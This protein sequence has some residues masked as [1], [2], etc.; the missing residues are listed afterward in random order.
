M[1]ADPGYLYA[2]RVD[3]LDAMAESVLDAQVPDVRE[4]G[5]DPDI[6]WSA[7]SARGRPPLPA[8]V[9]VLEQLQQDVAARARAHLACAGRDQG[10]GSP[11]AR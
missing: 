3:R 11:S 7:R 2:A 6:G 8:A 4:P 1:A 10:P 9:H 5:V